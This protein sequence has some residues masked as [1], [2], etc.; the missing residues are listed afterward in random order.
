MN[1]YIYE[2]IWALDIPE[3]KKIDMYDNATGGKT[4]GREN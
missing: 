1:E 3:E 4:H 2:Q